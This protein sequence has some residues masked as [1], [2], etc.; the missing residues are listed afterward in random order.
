MSSGVASLFVSV[1]PVPLTSAEQTRRACLRHT[2]IGNECAAAARRRSS[3]PCTSI[4]SAAAAVAQLQMHSCSRCTAMRVGGFI[5]YC[6]FLT[7]VGCYCLGPVLLAASRWG[8]GLEKEQICFSRVVDYPPRAVY[9]QIFWP[10]T[11]AP[12]LSTTTGRPEGPRIYTTTRCAEV[13]PLGG[14]SCR[15]QC[16]EMPTK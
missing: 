11:L 16:V 14:E 13:Q 6:I 1:G 10:S 2:T 12:Q 7:G 15:C 8:S 5:P 4:A 9:Q 3:S